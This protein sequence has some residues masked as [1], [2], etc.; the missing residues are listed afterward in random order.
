MKEYISSINYDQLINNHLK[1]VIVD[2]LF[3]AAD[4]GL[5]G[6]HHFYITFRT[7]FP[8]VDIPPMLKAQYPESMTIVLQ[9]QFSNLQIEEDAFSVDLMFGGVSYTLTIPYDSITYFA[10]PY[11]HFGLSFETPGTSPDKEDLDWDDDDKPVDNAP[12]SHQA[13]VISIDRFRKK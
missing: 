5:P 2:A 8:G 3:I 13:E 11:A 6:E 1:G 10:D 9:H 7:D 12:K 4:Q